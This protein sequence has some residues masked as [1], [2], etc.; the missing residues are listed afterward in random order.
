MILVE[1][2]YASVIIAKTDEKFKSLLKRVDIDRG[3]VYN[4]RINLF[5]END[6]DSIDHGRLARNWQ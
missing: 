1:C 3:K 2:R 4:I 5:G 6:E